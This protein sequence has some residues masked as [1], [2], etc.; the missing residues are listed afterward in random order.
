MSK[1]FHF[2]KTNSLTICILVILFLLTASIRILVTK[3]GNFP[4]W[5]DV[6]RDAIISRE[7]IEKKDLKLS[8]KLDPFLLN[9][10]NLGVVIVILL[11]LSDG[12]PTKIRQ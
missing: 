11:K 9:E 10:G 3:N 2:I 5:F 8:K 7:I 12:R 1:F 4:F 6:G